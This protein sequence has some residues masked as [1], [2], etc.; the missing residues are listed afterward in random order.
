MF[1][2]TRSSCVAHASLEFALWAQT[3]LELASF[4]KPPSLARWNYRSDA[5]KPGSV[6][7]LLLLITSEIDNEHFPHY[8]V[9][10]SS[11]ICFFVCC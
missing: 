10:R 8:T 3:G 5:T 2:E 11:V 7:I 1:F 4:L 6:L 9:R